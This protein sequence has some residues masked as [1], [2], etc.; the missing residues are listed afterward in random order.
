VP[1]ELLIT[2]RVEN[3]SLADPKVAISTT[4]QVAYGTDLDSLIPRLTNAVAQVPRVIDDPAPGVMLAGFA[5]D[6]L[7]LNVAFWIRDPENGQ[8]N[9]RSDVNLAIL[10][11]LVQAGVEIPFPQR[12]VRNA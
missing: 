3:S 7:E 10:R 1:N 8:N 9:A 2:Q 11:T 4:V 6:G 5:A 12:V